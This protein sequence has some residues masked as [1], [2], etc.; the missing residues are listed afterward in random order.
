MSLDHIKNILKTMMFYGNSQITQTVS[1]NQKTILSVSYKKENNM[2]EITYLE[3]AAIETHSE[4]DS[5]ALA[6]EETINSHV[7]TSS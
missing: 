5:T 4:V 1:K 7:K 2:F 3:P 6:I